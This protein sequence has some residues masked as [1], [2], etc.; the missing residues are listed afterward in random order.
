M[1]LEDVGDD[2]RHGNV[3]RLHD[4]TV[5]RHGDALAVEMHGRTL[6]HAAVGTAAARF[7]GGLRDLG[8]EP[9]DALLLYLP[10]C[11]QYLLASLGA[12]RAGVV[13]SPV[14]PQY[15]VRELSYQLEDAD[16][17]AVVTHPALGETVTEALSETGREPVVITVAGGTGTAAGDDEDVPEGDAFEGDVRFDEVAGEPTLVERDDDDVALL[18]YTSG[19]T[20]RPKGVELTHRNL[21]A[22]TVAQLAGGA[23][24]LAGEEVRSLVWL[25]LYHITGFTHTAWQPLIRGGALYLRSPAS[26]DPDA[27]MVLIEAA[28]VTHFVG[29]TAM[30]VDMVN[31]D[32]FGEHDLGSL[33]LAAE[34]GAK[35][36]VSVQREFE[37]MAGVEMAEGYGLTETT[38]ATH[39]QQGSTYGLRHGTVGQP[40]RMTDCKLVDDDGEEVAVGEAG[41]LLV[42]G[43]QVM[44]GY[45]GMPEA[46]DAAFTETGYFRTGDVARRDPENYYEIVDR[47]THVIVSA[48][49]N[50]YPSEV[51]ELLH[52][53]DAVAD[54]AVVGVPDERRNEVPIAYVVPRPGVEPGA[55][56]TAEDL[57]RYCLDAIAA[58]KH[59]RRVIFLDDLPRTASGKVQKFKLEGRDDAAAGGS[60][61]V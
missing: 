19:T 17:R 21:R 33:V 23:D 57:K 30:Y 55:D 27:A 54:A 31:A 43:P 47:K 59:P 36:S 39:S 40:L 15:R 56:V 7:A 44:R 58:Y 37:A 60:G 8:L 20:G 2:A 24:D 41:E 28:G 51:E 10:N 13:V 5:A 1:R 14:N 6:T 16:A 22:Q 38:G 4:E 34:G 11:P 9:G 25:P 61:E 42:R 53:H 49:Y 35:M 18:P 3:A 29:V 48:G 46:T 26:W 50:V 45:H 52:E 32:S 12:F